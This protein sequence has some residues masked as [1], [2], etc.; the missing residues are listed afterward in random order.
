[1]NSKTVKQS[2]TEQARV[3]RPTHLNGFD[4]LF[5][6]QLALWID[7]IAGIVALRH[8]GTAITTAAIDNLRFH[9]SVKQNDLVVLI[10]RITYVGRTSMEVRV[11]SYVE[12]FEG[13]RKLINT[14]FLI[15]VAIDEDGRPCEVPRLELTNAEEVAAFEAGKKRQELRKKMNTLGQ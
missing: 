13:G 12:D 11:D 15:E 14:A 3:V 8:S 10:A 9:K 6:G 5:G 4:R 1:M 2:L 7:E